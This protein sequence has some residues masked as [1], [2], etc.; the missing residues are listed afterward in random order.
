VNA[1]LARP[2]LGAEDL[3]G[4]S[5]VAFKELEQLAGNRPLQASPDVTDALAFGSPPGGVGASFWVVAQP[6]H[7]DRVECPVELP[8]ARSVQPMPGHSSGGGRDRVGAGQGGERDRPAYDQLT[9][10]RTALIGPTPGSSSSHGAVVAGTLHRPTAPT[11]DLRSGEVQQAT[12]VGRIGAHRRL[13]EQPAHH[14]GG[15]RGERVAVGVYPDYPSMVP[16]SLVIAMIP[17]CRGLG[18][19]GLEDTARHQ[20]SP[21][22]PEPM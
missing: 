4:R 5:V 15:G 13:C 8:A 16:A 21:W 10:T 17:P 6:G 12:M 9:S 20:D 2:V 7:H 1:G 14:I 18:R 11:R 3:D 19:V 22:A